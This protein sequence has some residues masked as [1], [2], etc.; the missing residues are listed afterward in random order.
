MCIDG[1]IVELKLNKEE[2]EWLKKATTCAGRVS[3]S[4]T[5]MDQHLR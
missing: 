3:Q 1:V 5:L 4:Q 2:G